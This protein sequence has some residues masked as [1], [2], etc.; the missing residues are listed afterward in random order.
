MS[1]K[2]AFD[3][4]AK[5]IGDLS[6][7]DVVSYTGNLTATIQ[8]TEGDIIDWKKLVKEAKKTNGSATLVLASHFNFDGDATLFSTTGQ[9]PTDIR[10]AHNEAVE[11]GKQ[12]RG[13]LFDLFSDTLKKLAAI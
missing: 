4:L 13:E 6:T 9:I 11:L 5:G 7:L 2:K 8:G 10:A 3:G 12:I 1:L